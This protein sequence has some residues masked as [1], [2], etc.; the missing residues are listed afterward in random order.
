MNGM[1]ALV[2]Y[3]PNDFRLERDW[4]APAVFGDWAL[5]KVA[6]AGVCGSDMPRFFKTG[7]YRSPMI[8]G[9]EF[10]GVV[11]IPAPDGKLPKGTPVAVLPIIP[12]GTCEGC[13]E[14]GE[15][16]QC[17]RY[18]FI[19]SRND[20]GFAE[21]CLVKEAN[22]FPLDSAEDLKQG[23]FIELL[24]VGLHAVRRSG[25]PEGRGAK[26]AV[27]GAGPVGIAIAFWLD[28]F[29][30]DVT[31]VDVRAFSLNIARSIGLTKAV[32]F[33]ETQGM[34]FSHVFEASGAP[35]VLERAIE[36]AKSK[37]VITVVGR[38]G[39][40]TVIPSGRF[41]ALMRKELTLDGCWG[42]NLSGEWDTMRRGL[43]RFD[44][45]KLVSH[46]VKPED[47]VDMLHAM[48]D[49]RVEY[50]KVLMNLVEGV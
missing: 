22:L 29:G 10:S 2:L 25:V 1:K 11:E 15:P 7:S 4:P 12:C 33:E 37:G 47:M 46:L 21:Y 17:R 13:L 41:E 27:F 24:S 36:T 49:G 8:L 5:V 14:T 26:A 9:H 45:D 35:A 18:Q 40:D 28:F 42:Y 50:C 16:F 34:A 6:Y 32:L 3:G 19:G 20:G 38:S 23:A 31:I 43:A 30:I 44:A 39:G 48:R